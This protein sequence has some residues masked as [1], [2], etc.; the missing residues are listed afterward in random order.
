MCGARVHHVRHARASPPSSSRAH[1]HVH[2][3]SPECMAT[4]P[5]TSSNASRSYAFKKQNH[6]TMMAHSIRCIHFQSH[7]YAL[8]RAL[9]CRHIAAHA[10]T[11]RRPPYKESFQIPNDKVPPSPHMASRVQSPTAHEQIRIR[12]KTKTRNT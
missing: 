4:R 1:T 7:V 11:H 9:P 8:R 3:F 6:E 10:G 2:A 5:F 12:D